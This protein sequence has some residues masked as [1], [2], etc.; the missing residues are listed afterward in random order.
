M[1]LNGVMAAD[2][3]FIYC[4]RIFIELQPEEAQNNRAKYCNQ[5]TFLLFYL[6]VKKMG[7]SS[8][9]AYIL[10]SIIKALCCY[11]VEKDVHNFCNVGSL[12]AQNHFVNSYIQTKI[13]PSSNLYAKYISN[14]F[15]YFKPVGILERNLPLII[16]GNMSMNTHGNIYYA[17]LEKDD[18]DIKVNTKE[19]IEHYAVGI[20]SY[21]LTWV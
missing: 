19:K 1:C 16:D 17:R 4:F 14:N 8:H 11:I 21:V 7:W 5:I 15:Q 12:N 3:S 10:W 9:P 18:K 20:F 2:G 13:S 6:N